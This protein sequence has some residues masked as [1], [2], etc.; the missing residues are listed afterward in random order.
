MGEKIRSF[1]AIELDAHVRDTLT[2]VQT[3]L[4]RSGAHVKWVKAENI[5]LTLKFLGDVDEK[6]IS[7]IKDTLRPPLEKISPFEIQI[8]TP[9]A[10][11]NMNRPRAIWVGISQGN[12]VIKTIVQDMEDSLG[13]VGFKKETRPFA[14]HI[15]IGRVRSFKNIHQLAKAISETT[16]TPLQQSINHITLFKSTLT[17]SGPIYEALHTWPLK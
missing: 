13:R 12:E 5:H 4:R 9:G 17:S 1:I 3:T 2:D 11:P 7:L 6:K 14:S 8:S 15:T 10:F 16:L